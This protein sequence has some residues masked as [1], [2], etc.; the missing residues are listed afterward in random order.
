MKS[1]FEADFIGGE[2]IGNVASPLDDDDGIRF[3]ESFGEFVAHEARIIEAVEVVMDELGGLVV[4]RRGESI[5]LGDGET[6]ARDL[7]F[8][9]EPFGEAASESG[10]A[11]TNIADEF[12]NHFRLLGSED[13]RCEITTEL[14][15]RGFG[16]DYYRR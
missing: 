1:D 15:H 10:F 5:A 13:L 3:G 12:K 2:Q 4:L 8:N 11:G 7:A 16:G 9:A 14:E 6:R